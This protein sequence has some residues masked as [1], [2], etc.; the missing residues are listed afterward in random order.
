[1]T[2]KSIDFLNHFI[3]D[4]L[5]LMIKELVKL[6]VNCQ[7]KIIIISIIF[8]NSPNNTYNMII[9]NNKYFYYDN[10]YSFFN[11]FYLST[12]NTNSHYF[13]RPQF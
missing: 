7:F 1:M 8:F 12:F 3:I 2:D 4:D 10:N 9:Y 11:I 5:F 13:P 6:T